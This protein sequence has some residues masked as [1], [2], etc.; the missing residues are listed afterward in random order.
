[1]SKDYFDKKEV[2]ECVANS[3]VYESSEGFEGV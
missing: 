1:M 2:R 3:L